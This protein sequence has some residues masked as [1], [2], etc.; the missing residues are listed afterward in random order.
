M[1]VSGVVV[2]LLALTIFVLPTP[3]ARYFIQSQLTA[4]G[5]ESDGTETIEVDL[6]NSHV[7]AGPLRFHGATTRDGEIGEVSFD[8]SVRQL[9]EGNAFVRT[10]SLRGIDVFIARQEDGS[11]ELNGV[12]LFSVARTSQDSTD[13][14]SRTDEEQAQFGF[15]VEGFE[16]TDSKLVFEDVTGGLLSLELQR[17]TLD[18]L[19]SWTPDEP[20]TFTL[21][22]RLNEMQVSLDGTVLPLSDPLHIRLNSAVQGVTIERLARF[23]GPTGLVRQEGSLDTRVHYDFAFHRDGRIETTVDGSY[24]FADMAITTAAG[25]E[26]TIEGARLDLDVQTERL[27]D[28]SSSAVG[29]LKLRVEPLSFSAASGDGVRLGSIELSFDDLDFRKSAEKRR[30]LLDWTPADDAGGAAAGTTDGIIDLAIGQ[31]VD[32]ARAAIGHYIEL[33]GRPGLI[34]ED[35]VL[36]NA[37]RG[38]EPGKEL[39]FDRL[40]MSL[41]EVTNEALDAGWRA[42]MGLE[43]TVQGLHAADDGDAGEARV[44][45]ARLASRAID[46]SVT[47]GTVKLAFDLSTVLKTLAAS[48]PEGA[49]VALD[50]LSLSTDGMSVSREGDQREA[51]GPLVLE[52]EALEASLPDSG[53]ADGKM[54]MSAKT[55]GLRLSPVSLNEGDAASISF[56]GG[57]EATGLSLG[58]QGQDPLSL[59]LA[60]VRTDFQDLRVSPLGADARVEGGL[61]ARLAGLS[62]EAGQGDGAFSLSLNAAKAQVGGL[63]A[64]GFDADPRVSVASGL[65]SLSGFSGDLPVGG[66]RNVTTSLEALEAPFSELVLQDQDVRGAGDLDVSGIAMNTGKEARSRASAWRS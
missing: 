57:L 7:R 51:T 44:T 5:I 54:A 6:W 22:G 65:T 23:V 24:R 19:R 37:G 11:I 66:G 20:T 15:G 34:L 13:E 41:G 16:F 55:L 45:E 42:T 28:E 48:N 21:E 1:I 53:G 64:S 31:V 61:A 39:R 47:T 29:G 4:L 49:S 56:A 58:L 9:L 26:L 25:D 8:Y 33:D 62:V 43:T 12:N 38:D 18:N 3:L 59:A 2:V 40:T 32:L 46:L 30:T 52:M 63:Q 10:F 14:E 27:P 50:T 35:G 60:E 36:R 17:L